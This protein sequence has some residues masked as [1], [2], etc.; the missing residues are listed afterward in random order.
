MSPFPVHMVTHDPAFPLTPPPGTLL[1]LRTRSG[2]SQIAS[3]NSHSP[4]SKG[5][6][7]LENIHSLTSRTFYIPWEKY[8]SVPQQ[9]VPNSPPRTGMLSVPR[10]WPLFEQPGGEKPGD[11]ELGDE[12]P[13]F[14]GFLVPRCFRRESGE[15]KRRRPSGA[16]PR[17]GHTGRAYGHFAGARCAPGPRWGCG[18]CCPGRC[19][20]RPPAGSHSK[21]IWKAQGY[22]P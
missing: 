16:G 18:G 11:E 12:A 19:P 2:F 10:R 8:T 7:T 14:S 5:F 17:A 22:L 15:A 9:N 4:L 6:A 21:G 3:L 1:H 20:R 13:G